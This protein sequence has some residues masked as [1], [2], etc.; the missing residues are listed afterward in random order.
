LP[1]APETF[2]PPLEIASLECFRAV[3]V[4]VVVVVVIVVVMFDVVMNEYAYL[5]S[6]S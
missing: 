4:V 5:Y 1:R 2:A 3:V 6:A